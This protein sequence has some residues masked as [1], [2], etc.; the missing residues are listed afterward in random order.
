MFPRVEGKGCLACLTCLLPTL[1]SL[2]LHSKFASSS[3]FNPKLASSSTF[4]PKLASSSTLNPQP[5]F[6]HPQPR[7]TACIRRSSPSTH[8]LYPSPP[9]STH[10]LYSSFLTLHPQSVS[11]S[12]TLHPQ[13][14]FV[15]PHPSPTVCIRPPSASTLSLYSSSTLHP[16]PVD[17][18]QNGR[19]KKLQYLQ[20]VP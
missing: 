11:F 5:V 14:V 13:P 6:V 1:L 2:T 19:M 20:T 15:L 4:N 16:Q 7:P 10:S 3:T 9:P 18:P 17:T 8:S 12:P